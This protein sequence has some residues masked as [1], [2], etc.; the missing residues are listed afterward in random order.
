MNMF[1]S[2]LLSLKKKKKKRVQSVR[3]SRESLSRASE[4]PNNVTVQ[5]IPQIKNQFALKQIQSLRCCCCCCCGDTMISCTLLS[6]SS[7]GVFTSEPFGFILFFTQRR[8]FIKYRRAQRN[9]STFVSNIR[10]FFLPDV[11]C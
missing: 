11:L 4:S 7:R 6:K 10:L 8:Q 2:F 1:H 3:P 5:Q 9:H